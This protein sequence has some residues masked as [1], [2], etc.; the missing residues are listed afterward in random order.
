[1]G[2]YQKQFYQN[3]D[4]NAVDRQ[5][6]HPRTAIWTVKSYIYFS[7]TASTAED[8]SLAPNEPILPQ[9]GRRWATYCTA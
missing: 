8:C 1:M 9:Y 2:R 3:G 5:N 4:E 6:V 7:R